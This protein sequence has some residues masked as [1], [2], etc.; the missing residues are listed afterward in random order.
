VVVREM[1]AEALRPTK[2]IVGK[3]VEEAKAFIVASPM[4]LVPPTGESVNW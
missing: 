1:L 2:W 3:T 4:P